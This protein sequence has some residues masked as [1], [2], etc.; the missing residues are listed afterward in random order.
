MTQGHTRRRF[1]AGTGGALGTAALWPA[2]RAEAAGD[3]EDAEG[4]RVAVLGGGVSGLSA[5]HE[6][7]ERGYAVTVYEYYD[8]LGGKA[9][10]M[11]VPGTGEGGRKPLPGEHGF[12]FVPGFYRNL[13]DTLRRIPF[14]GNAQGVHDNLRAGT[15]TLFA[16]SDGR[17]DLHFPLRRVTTPP[18][19]QDI[20]PGWIRDQLLAALQLA[21]NMPAHELGYFVNRLLV[22][23]TSCELRRDQQ[24][25]KVP[26]W[27]FIRAEDFSEE[28]RR[29]FGIGQSRNLTATKA[30]ESS[31][32]TVAGVYMENFLVFGLLGLGHDGDVDRVLNGPTNEA[33]LDPWVARLR[34]LGVEFVLSTRVHDVLYSGGQV[35][36]VRVSSADGAGNRVVT[37]DH[38]ISALPV[39]HAR[40]T[41]GAA[42]RAADPQLGRCDALRTDWMVGVQFYMRTPSPM[43]NGHVNC[44][45]SPWSV[46]AVGQAQFWDAHDFSA[47][48]GD[49]RAVDCVSAIASEW[50]KPGILYGKTAKQCTREEFVAE[51]WAQLTDAVGIAGD[52]GLKDEDR[53]GWFLDPA[54]TGMGGP[55]PANREQLLIHP[56]GSLYNRPSARTAV[57]N[58][59]LAGD[60]I[61]TGM[62]LASMEGANEAARHAV[63]ALLDADG[64][65]TE[66][67]TT[68]GHYRPPELEPLKRI[69][70]VRFGLGLPN[71]F[72]LG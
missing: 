64:S 13:P 60:Y 61:R 15:E 22:F 49:G 46:T 35:T 20:T 44:L 7:V 16:R 34:S 43:V 25:E 41:W 18:R 4:K 36:G 53:L 17:A 51:V 6:L 32:R 10:S 65:T 66:R 26:W 69:D 23:L 54:V 70:E 55:E 71:T 12:R 50:D 52:P 38:Y 5:A 14:A 27:D 21:T 39:E 58:F 63:N 9:R 1:L 67:C 8:V 3:A 30:E 62:N 29:F 47:E 57:P 72:D 56:T 42:L 24:W 68:W 59:F 40:P 11:D 31:T 28:Y 45:D 2:G 37:A 33:W 19:P 48:Y